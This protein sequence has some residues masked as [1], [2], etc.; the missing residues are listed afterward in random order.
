[1]SQRLRQLQSVPGPAS[2]R[3]QGLRNLID[4]EPR[5]RTRTDAQFGDAGKQG[6]TI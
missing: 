2:E 6:T 3:W 5:L 1:M 4:H